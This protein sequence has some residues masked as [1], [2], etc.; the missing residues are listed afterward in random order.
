MVLYGEDCAGL[1]TGG[2]ALTA[3][4]RKGVIHKCK[5]Q[6]VSEIADELRLL[7]DRESHPE[8]VLGN[9]FEV[10]VC[11]SGLGRVHLYFAGWPCQPDSSMGK[12]ARGRDK[13][14]QPFQAI[15]S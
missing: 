10:L 7:L 8:L 3:L 13:R 6:F 2:L 15:V 5:A 1:G 11:G 12:K 14:F 9:V 4:Q